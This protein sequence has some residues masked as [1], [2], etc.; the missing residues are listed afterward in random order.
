M[1]GVGNV[2]SRGGG[3]NVFLREGFGIFEGLKYLFDI[4]EIEF[5]VKLKI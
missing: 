3:M 1:W 4:R 5:K 2:E